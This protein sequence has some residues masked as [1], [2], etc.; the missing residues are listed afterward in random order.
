M[1]SEMKEG[2]GLADSIRHQYGRVTYAHKTQ[3]IEAELLASKGNHWKLFELILLALTTS[4]L[5]ALFFK[6]RAL[7][8]SVWVD[9]SS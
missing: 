4:G 7:P 8:R 5:I 1:S 3:I 2:S 6:N 9:L